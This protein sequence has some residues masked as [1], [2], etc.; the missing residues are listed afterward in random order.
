M[1]RFGP[2]IYKTSY[3]EQQ[4]EEFSDKNIKNAEA[5]RLNSA[6]LRTMVDSSLQQ[7]ANDMAKQ[8]E[9]TD[10]AFE[11]GLGVLCLLD[12]SGRNQKI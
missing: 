1:S 9:L 8:I 12:A 5:T 11:L 2:G 3:T 4:W 7:A 10:R 6:Q